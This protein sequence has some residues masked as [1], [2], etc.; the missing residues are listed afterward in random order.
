MATMIVT[1][2]NGRLDL[3]L[4]LNTCHVH[5]D[6]ASLKQV[7]F[8]K[9]GLAKTETRATYSPLRKSRGSD[10]KEDIA[11]IGQAF[12]L[13]GKLDDIDSFWQALIDKRT[14]IIRSIDRWDH[15]SFYRHRPHRMLEPGISH[16]RKLALLISTVS[17]TRFLASLP[18]KL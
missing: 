8:A 6:F 10:E 13:P 1:K 7:I 18:Q 5:I 16:S 4:P 17:I 2:L 9:L 14:D 11:I 12:R 15:P 3:N